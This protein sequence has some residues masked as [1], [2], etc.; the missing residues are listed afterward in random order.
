M[1]DYL[2]EEEYYWTE[3]DY[4][5]YYKKHHYKDIY[6]DM[7]WWYKYQLQD[8]ELYEPT[9]NSEISLAFREAGET[10]GS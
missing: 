9:H 10:S 3:M 5:Y 6:N 2:E 7:E 1:D 8:E 4:N